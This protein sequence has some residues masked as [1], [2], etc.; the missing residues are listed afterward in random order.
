MKSL[1]LVTLAAFSVCIL[2]SPAYAESLTAEQVHGVMIDKNVSWITP[3]KEWKGV[4]RYKKNGTATVTVNAPEKF[5]DRG[6]WWIDG[7]KFCSKWKRIRD[8]AERCSTLRTTNTE[9]LYR[10]DSVFLRSK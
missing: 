1:K 2:Q 3:D 5:K 7:N 6:S 10:T 9:G 4:S 8:G